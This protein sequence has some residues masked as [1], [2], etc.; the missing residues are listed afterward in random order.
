MASLA[1]S[2]KDLLRQALN[3]DIEYGDITT[4]LTIFPVIHQ[5]KAVILAKSDL[6]LAGVPFAYELFSMYDPELRFR[7]KHGDS[8][9]IDSGTVIAIIKGNTR[10]LLAVERVA[11]NFLQR[12]SGIATLT[13]Q[14]VTAVSGTNAKIVD[15]RKTT[16]LLRPFEKYAVRVGGG[17]N[18]R[19]GLHDGIL[20]KDNHIQATGSVRRALELVKGMAP[21][22]MKIEIEVTNLD[23][24]TEAIEHGADAIL[25]DNMTPA[26]IRKAVAI[27][28]G[29]VI[30]EASGGITL[31]NVR[32]YAETGVD[33]ISVGALTH[34][35]IASDISMKIKNVSS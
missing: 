24:F 14:F 6:M 17:F 10:S 28:D 33:I 4:E 7:M 22:L 8:Q 20:I 5:S 31:D 9:Q 2:I 35:A 18:H 3:E 25:L 13:H 16:P 26:E 23:E 11:L 34:S 32:A 19:F 29:R 21:H 30:L 15:T 27:A 1:L 12:L